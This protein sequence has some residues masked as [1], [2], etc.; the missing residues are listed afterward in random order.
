MITDGTQVKVHYKGTLEDGSVFD[1]SEGRDPLEFT[2]GS[3]MV[4]AGFDAVVRAMEVGSTTTVTIP[5]S[6]AYGESREE[7]MVTLAREQFP[8]GITPEVG[9]QFQLNTPQGPLRATVSTI[10]D[11]GITLD[12]NHPLA[13]RDLTFEL[14]LVE[15]AAS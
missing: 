4:I 10:S 11:E 6:E 9:Q 5:C 1:S 7:M 12:A 3:G 14:T 13:G 8:E 2:I 15:A